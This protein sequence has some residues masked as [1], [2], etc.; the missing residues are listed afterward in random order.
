MDARGRDQDPSTQYL[1]VLVRL[2]EGVGE[3]D[4]VHVV[5]GRI[6]QDLGVDEE[7]DL[8]VWVWVCD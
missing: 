3:R 5:H 6:V 8:W 2:E 1:V 7:E 4:L